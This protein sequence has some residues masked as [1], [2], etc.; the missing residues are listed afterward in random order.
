GSIAH[1][2]GK[3]ES[4]LCFII[5]SRGIGYGESPRSTECKSTARIAADDGV[6]KYISVHVTCLH[7]SYHGAAHTVFVQAKA[8]GRNSRKF[9]HIG[10]R[11]RDLG[12]RRKLPV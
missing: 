2:N 7:L 5:Q 4:R 11:N 6:R 3:A 10:E 1:P 8:L 9:V 12:L